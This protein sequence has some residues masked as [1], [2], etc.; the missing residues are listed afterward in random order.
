MKCLL[1]V[2][3]DTVIR[4][5][6]E[7][8]VDVDNCRVIILVDKDNYTTMTHGHR[9]VDLDKYANVICGH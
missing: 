5:V 7:L 3:V 2:V 8:A 1:P 4:N 6:K 9:N